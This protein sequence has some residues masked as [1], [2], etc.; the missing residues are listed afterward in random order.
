MELAPNSPDQSSKAGES[1]SAPEARTA[2]A[3]ASM[4]PEETALGTKD[5]LPPV[6]GANGAGEATADGIGG[7]PCEFPGRVPFPRFVPRAPW[8]GA[9]LQ[10]VRNVLSPTA[11]LSAFRSVRLALPM[12]DG[13]GDVI[14]ASLDEPLQMPRGPLVV[15]IHGVAGCEDSLYMRTSAAFHLSH[16]SRVLRLNL[17]G[18]G[19]SRQLCRFEYHAGR[20]ADLRDALA[21]IPPRLKRGG[22]FIVG[23]SLG[24]NMLLKFLADH[25]ADVAVLGA[26]SVSAPIDL[27][28]AVRRMMAPR[29][30][31]YH[32]WLLRHMKQEATGGAADL[33]PA[34]R[35]AIRRARSIY[36]FDRDF[37]GPRHGYKGA[38]DYYAENSAKRYFGQIRV[39]TLVI[40]AHDDPWIPI[41]PYLD[42]D[43]K[44]YQHLTALLPEGGGHVG[45]HCSGF[46][47]PWHDACVRAF[48]D[49]LAP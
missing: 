46:R 26:T 41:G 11:D 33:S 16:G 19:P 39:P 42:I 21:A 9:D 44:Q 4:L 43:W 38:D 31:L 22:L 29:N 32:R 6:E 48:I 20:T 7:L 30:A 35:E 23:Y 45:F 27:A 5:D 1:V 14:L 36:E 17:R 49:E 15:L 2:S 25:G 47:S 13:S 34:E 40:H 8:W 24:G 28:A 12:R 37:V 10:T 18:A 3:D